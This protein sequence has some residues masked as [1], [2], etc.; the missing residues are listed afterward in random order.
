M[1]HLVILTDWVCFVQN[2]NEIALQPV[3]CKLEIGIHT[4]LHFTLNIII[5]LVTGTWRTPEDL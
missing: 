2:G 1:Y 3:A 5:R 4:K